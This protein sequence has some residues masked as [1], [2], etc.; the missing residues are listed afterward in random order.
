MKKSFGEQLRS[1]RK[2]QG[3]SVETLANACGI[4]RSYII[5]I[6]GGKRLPG[7]K[8]LPKISAALNLSMTVV[9][10]WYLQDVSAKMKKSLNL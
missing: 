2:K 10:N 4:S 9:L 8:V 6:E 1:E 7:K 5:L 3:I